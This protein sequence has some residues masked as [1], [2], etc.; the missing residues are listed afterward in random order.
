MDVSFVYEL[1]LFWLCYLYKLFENQSSFLQWELSYLVFTRVCCLLD[2]RYVCYSSELC[3]SSYTC[4]IPLYTFFRVNE[5]SYNYSSAWRIFD[6]WAT[7]SYLNYLQDFSAGKISKNICPPWCIF[8][9]LKFQ[10]CFTSKYGLKY[11][12]IKMWFFQTM[13]KFCSCL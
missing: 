11:N 1:L 5:S 4:F 2:L 7:C 13:V 10:I 8:L 6:V 3:H 12:D 9:T